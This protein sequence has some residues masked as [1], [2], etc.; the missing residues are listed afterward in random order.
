M[1]N[2]KRLLAPTFFAVALL[3]IAV[4][5]PGCDLYVDFAGV[6]AASE[7]VVRNIDPA[8]DGDVQRVRALPNPF[9]EGVIVTIQHS[10]I[11][12]AVL[13]LGEEAWALDDATRTL[14]P[15]FPLFD[16][17]PTSVQARCGLADPGAA[18]RV[19]S[20]MAVPSGS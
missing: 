2:A 17:A 3:G 15:S 10:T 11:Q 16:D 13:V 6:D 9:G 14:T 12:G 4:S 19:R 18:D 1:I 7:K 20:R 5:A 8:F